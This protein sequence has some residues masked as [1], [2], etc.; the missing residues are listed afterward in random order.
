M[1]SKSVCYS[2]LTASKND[3]DDTGLD[4]HDDAGDDDGTGVDNNDDRDIIG[5]TDGLVPSPT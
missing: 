5:W 4:N 2:V 3:D 1:F